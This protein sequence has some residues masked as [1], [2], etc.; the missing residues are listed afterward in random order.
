MWYAKQTLFSW[1]RIPTPSRYIR[2]QSVNTLKTGYIIIGEVSKGEMLSICWDSF[3]HDIARRSNVFHDLARI[4]LSFNKT[5]LP[6]IGS[7]TFDDQAC[8]TLTNRPLTLHLQSLENEGIPT[9]IDRK[10][11]YSAVEPYV[12]DLLTCHDHRIH[13]Q[14]NSIH[15]SDDGE[16]QLAALTMMRATL[17]H[18][19]HPEYRHGPF[20][21]TLTD[22]HPSNIYVDKDCHITSLIDLEWACSLPIEFQGPP[23]WL[24]GRAVGARARRAP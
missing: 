24:S 20:V 23:F 12:L 9:A 4:T 14:P 3:R 7:L 11:T 5:P 22:L 1:L 16:Q 13:Y 15:D 18:F 6:R 21:F 8:I 10:S 2:R 17:H 19:I